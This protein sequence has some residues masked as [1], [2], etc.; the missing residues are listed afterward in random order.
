MFAIVLALGS[1]LAYGLSDFLG[2]VKSRSAAATLTVLLVSQSTALVLL[3]AIVTALGE[4]MPKG[5]YLFAAL[6]GLCETVGIA[7]LYRGL[8]SG[9][10]STVAPIAAAAPVVPVAIGA[11]LGEYPTPVQGIG[12]ALA[13]T[14][15][16]LS[17]RSR[18]SPD[19]AAAGGGS[20]I[21]LGLVAA[22][23]FGGFYVSMDAASDASVPWALLTARSTAV[24]ALLAA[25]LVVRPAAVRSTDLPPLALIGALIVSADGMFALASTM[26]FLGVVAVLSSLHPVVTIALARVFLH[27]RQERVQQIGIACCLVGVVAISA[28]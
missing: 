20:S 26:D 27:E 19:A 4:G 5:L 1:S 23:G 18:P 17:S 15:I 11:I 6:A 10:M 9:T 12:I 13:V 22:L 14:G 8:A 25:F 2:G 21:V 16:V 24:A 7:A 28:G 3:I